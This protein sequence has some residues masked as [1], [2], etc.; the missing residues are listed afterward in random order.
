MDSSAA[1]SAGN[2][3]APLPILDLDRCQAVGP[4]GRRVD[5]SPAQLTLLAALG[6]L[7]PG[8]VLPWP[9]AVRLIYG[10]HA[11]VDWRNYRDAVWALCVRLNRKL[12][13]VG[14]PHSPIQSAPG[15]G[16]RLTVRATSV[17]RLAEIG[18]P[19][20]QPQ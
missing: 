12:R 20:A 15:H 5:I 4:D 8:H 18:T 3:C 1:C 19:S 16:L 13:G 10:E 7:P 2:E 17:Q 11:A 14:W 9:A 6:R